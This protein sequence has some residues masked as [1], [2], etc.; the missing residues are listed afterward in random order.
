[1]R[2]R[3]PARQKRTLI[4]VLARHRDPR[5]ADALAEILGRST[6]TVSIRVLAAEQ[7]SRLGAGWTL[8]AVQKLLAERNVKLK[9]AARGA[10]AR[11]CPTPRGSTRYYLVIGRLKDTT[12][13]KLQ[14]GRRLTMRLARLFAKRGDS[15]VRWPGC[16]GK[17]PAKV[18]GYELQPSIE[19]KTKEESHT[20]KASL[21]ILLHTR[22]ALKG[23]LSAKATFDV[24]LTKDFVGYLLGPLATSLK[25]DLDQFLGRAGSRGV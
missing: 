24:A 13:G 10:L 6:E 8:K 9:R 1:L 2:A 15:V 18:T 3:G 19:L 20:L 16:R 25:Q 21:V 12:P 7:L 4:Y 11:M 14:T 23:L 5:A 22:R 17:L